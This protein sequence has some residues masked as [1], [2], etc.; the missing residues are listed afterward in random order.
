MHAG[1]WEQIHRYFPSWVVACG[2][3]HLQ[4]L[5]VRKRA[6]RWWR[7]MTA[8]TGRVWLD[9]DRDGAGEEWETW[10]VARR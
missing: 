9:A 5:R 8:H 1:K 6:R 2:Y 10:A 4:F 7:V 3:V